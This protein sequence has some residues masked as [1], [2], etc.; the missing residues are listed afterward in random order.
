MPKRTWWRDTIEGVAAVG[1]ALL[2][3]AAVV[4]T[5]AMAVAVPVL[6]LW[7]VVRIA[8]FAWLGT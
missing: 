5:L 3:L 6:V 2:G 8:R 4:G 7:L 1:A